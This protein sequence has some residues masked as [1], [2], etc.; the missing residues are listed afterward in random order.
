MLLFMQLKM[1]NIII[2]IKEYYG[3]NKSSIV[4]TC[5][6]GFFLLSSLFMMNTMANISSFWS[7]DAEK[8]GLP[9]T[10]HE[11]V[12]LNMENR[13]SIKNTVDI[14]MYALIGL[15]TFAVI[16]RRD[17]INIAIRIFFVIS[18]S[19]LLRICVVSQTNLP[20]PSINCRK[21]VTNFLTEFGQDRC[22]DLIFSGHTIPLTVCSYTWLTYSFFEDFIGKIMKHI[23]SIC[24][25]LVGFITVFLIIICRNHYT[26][27]VILAI[28]TTT[29]VWIIY[30][31]IWDKYL[32]KEKFF[33]EI[34]HKQISEQNI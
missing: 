29:S 27:D 25:A 32:I 20:P 18:I 22:G 14:I 19:Y 26:I 8:I 15:T 31:Y 3:I 6:T 30:G 17:A 5:A 24:I 16:T 12:S 34:Y 21:I 13:T 9:D 7:I 2:K 4:I 28:Y 10:L 23:L 11:I 1:P 33:K